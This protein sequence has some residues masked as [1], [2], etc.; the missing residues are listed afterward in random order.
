M[1][2]SARHKIKQAKIYTDPFPHIVI[3]NFLQ[4]KKLAELNKIL[5]DYK[6]VVSKNVIFQSSSETKKTIMPDSIIF[7]KLERNKIFKD[8]NETFKK[9]KPSIIKKFKT[10]IKKNVNS[11]YL[12]SKIKYHMNF[13]LMKKGYLK[14]A[15]L[16]RRDHLISA[17]Y[18][19][20]SVSNKGGDLQL[21]KTKNKQKVFDVFPSKKSLEIAKKF[22]IEQNFCVAFLNVPWAYHA[23]NKYNGESDRK[24]FYIDYDFDVKNSGGISKNRKKGSNL[25]FFWKNEVK[26]KSAKRKKVFFS[27]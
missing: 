2:K 7:K 16:D 5:P 12:N 17:I 10:Q 3:K 11:N 8:V 1:I 13:A 18:Y 27:E 22:K 20:S 26:V 21:C 24:Y 19:P 14:S 9:I 15:H 6:D 23:V 4:K 25:N